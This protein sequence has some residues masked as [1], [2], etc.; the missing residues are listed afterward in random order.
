VA[1]GL[2]KITGGDV[3][4]TILGATNY[5]RDSDS[6]ATMG[7]AIAGALGGV[8]VVPREWR[9]TVGRESRLDLAATGLTMAA[10]AAEIFTADEKAFAHRQAAFGALQSRD[11]WATDVEGH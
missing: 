8:D 1:L 11:A 5:G 9:E 6:I 4:G 3:A 2:L 7:G 10:V